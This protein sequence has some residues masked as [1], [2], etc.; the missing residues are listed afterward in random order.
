MAFRL[1]FMYR[2]L[3]VRPTGIRET[4]QWD[5]AKLVIRAAGYQANV[6]CENLHM[7]AGPEYGI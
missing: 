7:C 4:L 1:V 3:R 6:D 2:R 5:L